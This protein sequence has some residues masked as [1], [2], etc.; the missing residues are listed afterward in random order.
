MIGL[1]LPLLSSHYVDG[2]DELLLCTSVVT[3]YISIDKVQLASFF[4]SPLKII[5]KSSYS[6]IFPE[7]E[8]SEG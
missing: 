3:C 5:S 8:T 4:I 7:G 1:S 2:L 6:E